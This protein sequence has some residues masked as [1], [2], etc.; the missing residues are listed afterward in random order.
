MEKLLGSVAKQA[1]K[2]TVRVESDGIWVGLGT[3]VDA[4]GLQG[5]GR[6]DDILPRSAL[7]PAFESFGWGALEIDGHDVDK[8]CEALTAAPV[9]AGRPTAIVARTVKGKGIDF[10]EHDPTWHH[11][12]NIEQEVADQMY[13]AL[14]S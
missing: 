1:G 10:A 8:L 12:S 6:S 2:S 3:I 4:N 7:R 5:Y 9:R 11:K 13:A 14:G